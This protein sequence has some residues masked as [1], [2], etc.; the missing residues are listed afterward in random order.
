MFVNFPAVQIEMGNSAVARDV[1]QSANKLRG[2]AGSCFE[3]GQ[4]IVGSFEITFQKSVPKLDVHRVRVGVRTEPPEKR[5]LWEIGKVKHACA[6]A[7]KAG[8]LHLFGNMAAE[9][10][11]GVTERHDFMTQCVL[12]EVF[13]VANL[14]PALVSWDPG[15]PHMVECMATNL[16]MAVDFPDLGRLHHLPLGVRARDI[17]G[18]FE[19]VF[20]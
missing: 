14:P 10:A 4:K 19:I 5:I 17:E 16:A 1:L 8:L 15:Q 6:R 13:A 20:Q 11:S 3:C 9:L 2:P 18:R 7:E 12:H